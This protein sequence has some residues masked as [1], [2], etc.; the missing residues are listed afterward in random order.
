MEDEVANSASQ[1]IA[2]QQVESHDQEVKPVSN[3]VEERKERDWRAIR[4]RQKELERELRMQKEVNDRLLQM[5]QPFQKQQVDEDDNIADDEFIPKGKVKKILQKGKQEIVQETLEQVK[6]MLIQQDQANFR[7][8]LKRQ[9]ADFD[10]V[11][12]PDTLALLEEQEPELAQTI[13]STQDPYKIGMQSY[14][15]IKALKLEGEVPSKR[16]KREVEKKI[17][18]NAQTVQSPQAYD[19]R[20]MAQAFKMTDAE[21][22][23]LYKEMNEYASQVGMSY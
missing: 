17:E 8:K 9:Y 1:E 15:Y 10:D 21:K 22:K 20:P 12:N 7:D 5:T 2:S 6:N 4:E 18:K 3:I 19:K 16:H 11:V 23:S 14:K 13:A